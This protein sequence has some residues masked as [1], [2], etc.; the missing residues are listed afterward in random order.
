MSVATYCTRSVF[1]VE[2]DAS[3]RAVAER[4]TQQGMGC[5]I[6]V[7][8]QRPVG[9]VTDRDLVLEVLCRRL[10]AGSVPVGELATRPA[11]TIREDAALGEAL[12][13]LGRRGIRRLPVVDD[14]GKLVGILTADDLMQ[15]VA[16]ELAGLG[17][18]VHAQARQGGM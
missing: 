6:V 11:I 12:R 18:A 5:A 17:A 16:G 7:E 15:V 9:I 1:R 4:M 8:N 13:T 2:A 10:D 3:A 14:G